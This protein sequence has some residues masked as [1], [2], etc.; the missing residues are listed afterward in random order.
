[1]LYIL[2]KLAKEKNN[3]QPSYEEL[4]NEEYKRIGSTDYFAHHRI[5]RIKDMEK[6]NWNNF[7]RGIP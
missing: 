3:P 4:A 2:D 6:N 1:M 5:E 7:L